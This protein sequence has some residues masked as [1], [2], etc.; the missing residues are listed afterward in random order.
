M[1][2]RTGLYA[3][4]A[5]TLGAS[6]WTWWSDSNEPVEAPVQ[7]HSKAHVKSRVERVQ[8]V[9]LTSSATS[10][11]PAA[12]ALQ[13]QNATPQDLFS[14][15]AAAI[16]VA[17][18]APPAA[19][20]L[21]FVYAGKLLQDAQYAVF[22]SMGERNLVVHQGDIVEQQWRVDSI[23]PPTMQLSYLPMHIKRVM[24]IGAAN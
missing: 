9:A 24:N 18:P 17:P 15:A 11:T 12:Q 21:P 3:V 8:S 1:N 14:D 10:N 16:A 20:E 13:S 7:R 22:L 6:V 4:L 2:S 19:P 5:L 23:T